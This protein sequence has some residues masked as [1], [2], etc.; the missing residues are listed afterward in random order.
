M[1]AAD[2]NVDPVFADEREYLSPQEFVLRSG[3]SI[4]TV[5]RYLRDGRL[6]SVQ[7]GGRRSRVLIPVTALEPFV[8]TAVRLSTQPIAPVE[9]NLKRQDR[10]KRPIPGPSPLWRSQT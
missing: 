7:P 1:V 6:P 4:A 8:A 9:V 5:R 2:S 10:T 3:L